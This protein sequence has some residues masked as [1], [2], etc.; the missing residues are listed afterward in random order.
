MFFLMILGRIMYIL[1]L[2]VL[3]EMSG[4]VIWL[5]VGFLSVRIRFFKNI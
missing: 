2:L 4:I 1:F 5:F 3:Y